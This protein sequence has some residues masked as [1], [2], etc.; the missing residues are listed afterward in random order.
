MIRDIA[1]FVRR[2][3]VDGVWLS[4]EMRARYALEPREGV[5]VGVALGEPIRPGVQ[6]GRVALGLR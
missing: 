3:Y 6:S 5:M 1:D 4:D 2:K